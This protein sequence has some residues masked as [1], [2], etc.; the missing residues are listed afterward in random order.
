MLEQPTFGRRLRE[1]RLARGLSQAELAA[2][3]LS[4]A[5]L[6][7]LES[8]ARPPTQ[9]VLEHLTARLGVPADAFETVELSALGQAL[10]HVTSSDADDGSALPLLD[11]AVRSPDTDNVDL[12]WVSLW[13]LTHLHASQ[14][15]LAGALDTARDLAALSDQIGVPLLRERVHSHLAWCLRETGDIA[16]ALVSAQV[17]VAIA[18]EH[19]VPRRDTVKARLVLVSVLAESGRMAE[20]RVYSD[21]LLAT[22]EELTGAPYAEVLWAVANVRL[23]EGDETGAAELLDRALGRLES[24]DAPLLSLRLRLAA[25]SLSLQMNPPRVGTAERLLHEAEPIVR[26]VGTATNEIELDVVRAHLAFQRR[27]IDT[28]TAL[29]ERIEP[30]MGA[31]TFRDRIR[32]ELLHNQVLVMR[33]HQETGVR[34]IEKLAAEAQE[35]GN[36]HLVSEVWRVLATTLSGIDAH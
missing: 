10:A 30:S 21:Q 19:A 17:A 27:D 35:R 14:G 33:G 5:Y 13:K 22:A 12:R 7:R 8:G 26:I 25:A 24:R 36:L 2:E 34:A 16:E 9:K 18:E 23:R 15:R 32:M 31:L 29:Y 11:A 20:A 4:T 6:S 3:G 28:V 1:L